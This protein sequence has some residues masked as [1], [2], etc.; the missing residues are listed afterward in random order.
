MTPSRWRLAV[1]EAGHIISHA[2]LSAWTEDGFVK[3]YK[4]W[5]PMRLFGYGRYCYYVTVPDDRRAFVEDVRCRTYAAG[6]AAEKLLFDESHDFGSEH[7]KKMLAAYPKRVW[8]DEE[9]KATAFLARNERW[10]VSAAQTLFVSGALNF[11][12]LQ[13]I[14]GQCK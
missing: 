6:C 12:A 4:W 14:W 10:F 3:L 9:A 8:D 1:H 11:P 5:H 13:H 7:D 2:P